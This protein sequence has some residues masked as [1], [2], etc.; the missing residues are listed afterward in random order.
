MPL[1]TYAFLAVAAGLL[2]G[3]G[4][5]AFPAALIASAGVV[6]AIIRRSRAW[7]ALVVLFIASAIGS[8]VTGSADARCAR[9]IERSG[10][11]TIRLAEDAGPR[12]STRGVSVAEG[13]RVRVRLRT[14]GA[15]APA[16]A[17]VRA[18]GDAGRRGS[19]I[20]FS[21]TEVRVLRTPGPLAR[22]RAGTGRLIDSLY[23]P[24][25]PLARALLIADERDIAPDVRRRYADAG[26][27]HMLSVSG[28]HVA[29]L[30][31]AIVLA[32][33]LGG[34]NT[35][36]AE[37]VALAA[38]VAFVVFVGAPA[39]AVRAAAMFGAVAVARR[40]QRPTSPWALLALGGLVPLFDVRMAGNIGYQLSVVGMAGLIASGLLARRLPFDR[41]PPWASRVGREM[42]ATV[43][44]SVATAPIIAWHFGRVSLAAPLTNLAA[45]PLF[46]L[47][48]PALFL[49]LLCAPVRPLA[50][51]VADAT[52]V[53][54]AGI[55]RVADVGAALPG[56]AVDVLPSA[57]TALL[58]AGTAAALLI[59]CASRYWA[60]PL[61]AALVVAATSVWWPL[62]WTRRG[63]L[64]LHLLDVGQGD[65]VALRTPRSRWILVD[66]GDAWRGTDAGSRVVV[67][68]L[69]RRGG[70]V[71]AL[72]MTHPHT[73]HIGGVASVVLGLRIGAV[74]DGGFVQGNPA[75]ASVLTSARERA[76]PW[77]VVRAGDVLDIDGVRISV[78]APDEATASAADDANEASVVVMVAYREARLLLTGDA[79]AESE[80]WLRR[81]YGA[82]LRA[83]VLK[84]G[85]HG[86]RTSSRPDFLD[87]VRPRLALVSVGAGNR[88]GHPGAEVMRSLRDRG[89]QVMRTDEDGTVVVSTDG[90][91]VRV[92]TD[93]GHWTLR[94]DPTKR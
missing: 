54:L 19:T 79:E 29:V 40:L 16:G 51:F 39:P 34:A 78:L 94:V 77:R 37:A 61:L 20:S 58:V 28:L 36:R 64:E 86:S 5:G 31:E 46:G 27:I 72:L 21:E 89:A 8:A 25:A 10:A 24:Q 73:D 57:T 30:A 59:A 70:D 35:R 45:A 67:P 62:V 60:R 71:A 44:A 66:A 17:L 81:R 69:R 50:Q 68:Y 84:V 14:S 88:Y 87:A 55:D 1:V 33:L 3:S 91:T 49:S 41:L 32:L 11:A 83:H 52:S 7:G 12:Q 6:I 92:S 22:W 2:L 65:A 82:G 4:G 76:V 38:I 26:I 53:L 15:S 18:V 9:M 43:V 90:R 74:L 47:A 42:L 13:C 63:P 48:Q 80:E 56:A 75:Y 23:G 85:H 93:D